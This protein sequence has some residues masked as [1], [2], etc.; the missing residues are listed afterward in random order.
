[1]RGRDD[2]ETAFRQIIVMEP[3]GRRTGTPAEVGKE[4]TG[5]TGT[6]RRARITSGLRATSAHSKLS[7]S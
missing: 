7:L 6:G 1:M 2:I 3:T 5:W 4:C